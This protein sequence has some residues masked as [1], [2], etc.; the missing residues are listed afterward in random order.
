MALESTEKSGSLPQAAQ[1]QLG[2]RITHDPDP[3]ALP[4][5]K[6]SWQTGVLKK[7]KS[8]S[9]EARVE[10]H[11]EGF[12]RDIHFG[13]PLELPGELEKILRSIQTIL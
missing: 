12:P 13:C 3:W 4:K 8:N 5:I 11:H 6:I 7:A 9:D 10:S 2:G 1:V